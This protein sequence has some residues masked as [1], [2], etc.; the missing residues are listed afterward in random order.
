MVWHEM[1]WHGLVWYDMI[2]HVHM[3]IQ[4]LGWFLSVFECFLPLATGGETNL[5]HVGC[6]PGSAWRWDLGYVGCGVLWRHGTS[7][8]LAPGELTLNHSEHEGPQ[9]LIKYSQIS[10]HRKFLQWQNLSKFGNLCLQMG[11]MLREL[12]QLRSQ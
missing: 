12:Q 9:I 7:R 3:F 8:S 11:Y 10:T 5:C 4:Q 2:W 6:L 1:V